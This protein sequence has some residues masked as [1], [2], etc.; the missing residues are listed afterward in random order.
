MFYIHSPKQTYM[1]RTLV[2][3]LKI[4]MLIGVVA[5]AKHLHLR[6]KFAN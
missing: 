2:E 1:Y 6:Q 3:I 5:K 4:T